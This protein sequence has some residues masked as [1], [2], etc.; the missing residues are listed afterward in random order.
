MAHT[1][2]PD[3]IDKAIKDALEDYA[4]TVFL[5]LDDTVKKVAKD[6]VNNLKKTSPRRTG[7]Y[8]KSWKKK[9][10]K[11]RISSSAIVYNEDH[12]RLTHLLENGHAKVN[13]GRTKAIPHIYQAEQNAIDQ[14]TK[15]LEERLT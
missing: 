8:A 1:I 5:D 6:T 4:D 9:M 10:E 3:K 12:Y 2:S 13:G 14:F 15:E 11:G 7:E